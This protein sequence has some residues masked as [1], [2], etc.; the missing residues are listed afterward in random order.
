MSIIRDKV[1]SYKVA[2]LTTL[3]RMQALSKERDGASRKTKARDSEIVDLVYRRWGDK[4]CRRW[5][6]TVIDYPHETATVHCHM[7]SSCL[8][9][10]IR[11]TWTLH[12]TLSG[13]K[14]LKVKVKITYKS[15]ILNRRHIILLK[16]KGVVNT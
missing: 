11:L 7:V 1:S 15:H 4:C 9:A 6:V 2:S 8:E 12:R 13:E 3:Q 16:S 14:S 5:G 10:H